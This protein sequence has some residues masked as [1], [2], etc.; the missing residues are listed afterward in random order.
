MTFQGRGFLFSLLIHA[1]F[2]SLVLGIGNTSASIKTPI[3]IDLSLLGVVETPCPNEG[4]ENNS[5][6]AG[7]PD[8]A[9]VAKMAL[10]G[11]TPRAEKQ[12]QKKATK[13]P[14]PK[15][16]T[17]TPMPD[18]LP[19]V[20]SNGPVATPS[21]ASQAEESLDSPALYAVL[22]GNDELVAYNSTAR[23]GKNG[24][25]KGATG[26][27]SADVVN[28]YLSQ[29]FD[30]IKSII[31][32]NLRYPQRARRMGYQGKVVVSFIIRED[33]NA[34]DIKV[35]KSS[36]FPALDDNVVSTVKAVT[37]FPR[38]PV[39]AVVQVPVSYRLD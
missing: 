22:T 5:A 30:Y 15:K 1:A 32:Q 2:I 11:Q 27:G 20:E 8:K 13:P 26:G 19:R 14:P 18:P 33:G 4:P 17:K 23:E 28:R 16:E 21:S 29:N 34:E 3:V 10:P 31:Q 6:G 35:A 38:P 24:A 9:C 25:G 36:G 37:P 7:K 12:A 39:E